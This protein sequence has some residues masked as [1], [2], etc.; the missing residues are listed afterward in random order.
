LRPISRAAVI[1]ELDRRLIEEVGI[2]GPVLMEHAAHLVA[3]VVR[4]HHPAARRVTVLCGPGNNGGD[5]YVVARHLAIAGLLVRAVPVLPPRTPDCVLHAGI[6]ARLGLVGDPLPADLVVD[7]IFG[8]GQ[9]GAVDVPCAVDAPMVAL[10]VPT[11]IDA[12]TGV[13][14]GAFPL[15]IEVITI[16]RLKPFLFA[17][18]C[19]SIPWTLVDIGQERVATEPPEALLVEGPSGDAVG[20]DASKWTRGHVG[21]YA[22]SAELAGAGVLAARAAL[23]AGAGLVTLLVPR[24]VWGRLSGLPAEVMVRPREELTRYDALVIGP[25][26]GR[27]ADD[28]VRHLWSSHPRP[29]V[30]DADALTALDATPSEHVRILTPHEGEAGRLLRE[31][32]RALARDRLATAARLGA[33]APTIYKGVH[34]IVAGGGLLRVVQ[35]AH[36]QLGT[37]GSGDVLAGLCGALLARGVSTSAGAADVAARAAAVHQRAGVLAGPVGVLASEI[38]DAISRAWA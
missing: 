30:F 4:A 34:P 24:E 19:A 29:C 37:G 32:G 27:S 3:D 25:G 6:A 13:R 14:V 36:P 18:E 1:R 26:L 9:R 8:T 7:A 28:D 15:P 38:A 5:G 2:P 23:R 33:I 17:G 21:V 22:G 10:D 20:A 12:D 16:G 11:G 35:G 31:D